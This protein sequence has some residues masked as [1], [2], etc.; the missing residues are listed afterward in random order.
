MTEIISLLGM[1]V[2]VEFSLNAGEKSNSMAHPDTQIPPVAPHIERVS[3][4]FIGMFEKEKDIPMS[5]E[6]LDDYSEMIE[7]SVLEKLG[8]KI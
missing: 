6:M 2:R 8:I 5:S 1:P 3:A 4:F 7:D